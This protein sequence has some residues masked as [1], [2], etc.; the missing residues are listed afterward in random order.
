MAVDLCIG[1][2]PF[3]F[4]MVIKNSCLKNYPQAVSGLSVLLGFGETIH[5]HQQVIHSKT[6]TTNAL[7][8]TDISGQPAYN[9][10]YFLVFLDIRFYTIISVQNRC[11]V[12]AAAELAYLR[13][14]MVSEFSY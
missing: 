14:R 2:K 9:I 11:V 5:N 1:P 6:P 8:A 3:V 13:K 12:P 4:N 10:L 7:L